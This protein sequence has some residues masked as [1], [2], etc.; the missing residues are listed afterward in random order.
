MTDEALWTIK[1]RQSLLAGTGLEI[2]VDNG[3]WMTVDGERLGLFVETMR[4]VVIAL[5]GLAGAAP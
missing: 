4:R 1:I 3:Y 2:T 5:E